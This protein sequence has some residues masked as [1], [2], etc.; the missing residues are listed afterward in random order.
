M[1]MVLDALAH[2]MGFAQRTLFHAAELA[3]GYGLS[4]QDGR[5]VGAYTGAAPV[6]PN[7]PQNVR[8]AHT[9]ELGDTATVN[10]LMEEAL[11]EASQADA[12]ASAE[13][14]KPATTINVAD[15]SQAHNE[16]LVE[17]SHI[18]FEM[19]RADVP[20]GK[21]PHLQRAWWDGLTPQQQKGLMLA[22]PV[23]LADL[24]GLPPEAGRELRG[25]DGKIDRVE[26]VR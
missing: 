7:V 13:L 6:G 10:G 18:E 14:D 21:D 12:K 19:L 8:D 22:D 24:K 17:A 4:I 3:G 23:S 15:T 2:S 16:L 5:A 26:M 11:R 1:A 20:V 25:P 9:K